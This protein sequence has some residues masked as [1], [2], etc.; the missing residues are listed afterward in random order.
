MK[1]HFVSADTVQSRAKEIQ[2]YW[3]QV[4]RT[5]GTRSVH[6]VS[7]RGDSTVLVADVSTSKEFQA[8]DFLDVSHSESSDDSSDKDNS[9]RFSY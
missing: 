9:F 4:L 2:P 7:C 5:I 6:S 1:F 3:D 8:H